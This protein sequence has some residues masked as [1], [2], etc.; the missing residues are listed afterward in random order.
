[1]SDGTVGDRHPISEF[2]LQQAENGL[3]SVVTSYATMAEVFKKKGDG[4]QPLTDDQN[5]RM[6]KYFESA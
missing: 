3:Y 5:G 2:V 6:M 1:L 4:N